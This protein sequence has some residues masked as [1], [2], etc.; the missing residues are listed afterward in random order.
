MVFDSSENIC[1]SKEILNYASIFMLK[2]TD[3]TTPN[4]LK[5]SSI[6]LILIIAAKWVADFEYDAFA[7]TIRWKMFQKIFKIL[8]MTTFSE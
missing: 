7:K 6:A 5:G 8:I 1:Y 3:R 2:D 4:L